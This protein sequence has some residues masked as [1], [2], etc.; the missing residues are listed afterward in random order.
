M[1]TSVE[2]VLLKCPQC[3]TPVPAEEDE[4]AWVCATCGQGLQLT[5]DALRLLPVH[6]ATPKAGTHVERWRPFWVFAGTVKF[7]ARESYTGH[8]EPEALWNSPRR[9]YVPAYTSP[10]AQLQSL[11][12]DLTQ[13]QAPLQAGP[14]AGALQGCTVFPAD[15]WHAVEF[16]VLTIEAARPDKLRSV[17]FDLN[18]APPELWMLP[19]SGAQV[20]P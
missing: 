10:L 7:T 9:F 14:A 4:V 3:S 6:W 20:L 11:G 1:S 15:A 16:I 12:A 5:E 18:L 19:F 2:L 17:Q 13:R 8:T